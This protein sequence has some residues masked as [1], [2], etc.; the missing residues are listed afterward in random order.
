MLLSKENFGIE[1][2]IYLFSI[3]VVQT[4]RRVLLFAYLKKKKGTSL[5]YLLFL[6]SFTF[7]QKQLRFPLDFP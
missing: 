3:F 4:D 6:F 2:V 5:T 7:Y 1:F